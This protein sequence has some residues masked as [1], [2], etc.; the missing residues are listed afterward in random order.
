M[1]CPE[2]PKNQL[3]VVSDFVFALSQKINLLLENLS[4]FNT[5]FLSPC[6]PSEFYSVHCG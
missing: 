3:H 5:V 2:Y 4:V 1:S 6:D